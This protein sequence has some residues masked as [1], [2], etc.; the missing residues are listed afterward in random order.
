M[1]SPSRQEEARRN[2]VIEVV[3]D[4]GEER[5]RVTVHDDM[6]FRELRAFLGET[7]SIDLFDTVVELRRRRNGNEEDG[8]TC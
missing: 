5:H 3:E 4:D 6:T 2:L 7:M 8:K 1:S